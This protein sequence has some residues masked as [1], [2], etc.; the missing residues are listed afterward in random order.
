ML[1]QT[2]MSLKP[3]LFATLPIGGAENVLLSILRN[4][5]PTKYISVVCCIQDKGVLGK[6]IEKM[7]IPLI[8][9]NLLQKR[10]WDR[11]IVKRLAELMKKEHIDLIHS[12]LYHANFYGRLAA[13][14]AHIPAVISVHNTYLKRKWHRE[15][16][17]WYLARHTSAIIAV[18]EDIRR[19]IIRFDRVAPALISV[20]LNGID[21]KRAHSPLSPSEAKIRLNIPKDAV[22]LGTIG[23]LEEQKGHRYLIEAMASMR[24][25]TPRL[26]L[27]IVG[28]GRERG[29]LKSQIERLGLLEHVQLLGSRSD[30]G[31][32][33]RSIDIFVMPSLWEGLSLAMLEAMAA[34]L[35]VIA[36]NVGGVS[37]VLGE[38]EFGFRVKAGD[39]SVLADKIKT[40]LADRSRLAQIGAKAAAHVQERYSDRAM[41][42]QVQQIYDSILDLPARK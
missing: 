2:I 19:D 41:T 10:G 17:N 1:M 9:L 33:L 31:D 12:H 6:D 14:R 38:D 21:L 42:Q 36:T 15:L 3:P 34:G 11:T 30:I 32:I 13:M 26:H 39:A 29:A 20:I 25:H 37:E 22:V 35:P 23:R 16:F 5:D 24:N 8:E 27:L 4:L 40:C 7:G 18:S 28:D